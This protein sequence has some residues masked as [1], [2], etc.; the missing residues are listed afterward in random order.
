MIS[1]FL[2]TTEDTEFHRV[3]LLFPSILIVIQRSIAT[4]DLECIHV[5]TQLYVPEILRF[6]LND[7]MR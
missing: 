2:G 3:F 6:A 4:K 7:R 1:F 5:Y